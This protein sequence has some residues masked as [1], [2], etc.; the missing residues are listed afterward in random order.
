MGARAVNA[1]AF[2]EPLHPITSSCGSC[3][4]VVREQLAPLLRPI[5]DHFAPDSVAFVAKDAAAPRAESLTEESFRLSQALAKGNTDRAWQRRTKDSWCRFRS[6]ADLADGAGHVLD[7]VAV[8]E[9]ILES[10]LSQAFRGLR[11]ID[12]VH[13]AAKLVSI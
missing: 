12:V 9:E 13:K 11:G 3:P 7:G 1:S 10:P 6:R 2:A 8:S 4:S 5:V